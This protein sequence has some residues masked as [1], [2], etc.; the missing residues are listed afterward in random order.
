MPTFAEIQNMRVGIWDY[1]SGT[2][3]TVDTGTLVAANDI[4]NNDEV[5]ILTVTA[6]AGA[7]DATVKI[8]NRDDAIIPA[9]Q[10]LTLTPN[11]T[12]V[13]PVIIFT[14]TA[15]YVIEYVTQNGRGY[16]RGN[17]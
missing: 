4:Q 12:I 15:S 3:G 10:A 8:D 2:S 14:G 13:N 11:G 1:E 6:I 16:T 5:R 7:S 17:I 9:G